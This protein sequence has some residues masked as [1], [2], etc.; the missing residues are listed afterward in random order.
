MLVTVAVSNVARLVSGELGSQI[1]Q[2]D[3]LHVLLYANK[4]LKHSHIREVKGCMLSYH[5][6]YSLISIP[7]YYH[8]VTHNSETCLCII[9]CAEDVCTVN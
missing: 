3:V 1:F 6:Y 8:A 7:L 4:K 5:L 2:A 9:T